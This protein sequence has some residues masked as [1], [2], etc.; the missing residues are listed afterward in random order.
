[1]YIHGTV[2]PISGAA[3]EDQIQVGQECWFLPSR[4]PLWTALQA[5]DGEEREKGGGKGIVSQL[6]NIL[7]VSFEKIY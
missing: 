1:M 4:K 5:T 2:A 6:G 3:E 7:G